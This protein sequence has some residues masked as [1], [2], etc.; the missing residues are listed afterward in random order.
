M[1]SAAAAAEVMLN[2]TPP[3]QRAKRVHGHMGIRYYSA[4]T[5]YMYVKY[6]YL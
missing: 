1:L 4:N 3:Q 6:V 5:L 2:V